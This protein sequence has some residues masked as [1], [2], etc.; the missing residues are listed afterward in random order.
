MKY[1]SAPPQN[2]RAGHSQILVVSWDLLLLR[3]RKL[4]LGT[5][6]QVEGAG[7]LSEAAA[8]L[9]RMSW[10]LV[11]LCDTLS[12]SECLRICDFIAGLVHKPE[13]LLLLD[14][15]RNRPESIPGRRMRFPATP[16]DLLSTCAAMLGS[17]IVNGKPVSKAGFP[18]AS[19][20]ATG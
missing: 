11:V 10:D 20:R 6:F 8:W 18:P 17:P 4:I 1:Q 12:D 5:Y 7:R 13:L 16:L 3:T 9:G 19:L 14:P 2:G 15:V